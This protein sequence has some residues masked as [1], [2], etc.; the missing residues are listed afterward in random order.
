M[1]IGAGETNGLDFNRPLDCATVTLNGVKPAV[2]GTISSLSGQVQGIIVQDPTIV[3]IDIMK[4]GVRT[5]Q[6]TGRIVDPYFHFDNGDLQIG[7]DNHYL[8]ASTNPALPFA[9]AGDSGALVVAQQ[10]GGLAAVGIQVGLTS[11]GD[12]VALPIAD[13]LDALD[14]QV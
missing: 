2:A 3:L 1:A 9:D 6:T 4:V 7:F 8:I 13:A 11:D 12:A 10:N 5:G 14:L